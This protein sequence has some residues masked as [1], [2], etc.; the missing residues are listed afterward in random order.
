MS[1]PEK[2]TPAKDPAVASVETAVDRIREVTKWLIGAFA[3]V[4][5]VLA[6]G[7]Q[8]S[9]VGDLTGWRLFAAF[10]A[11]LMALVGIAIAI[12]YA[13]KVLTPKSVSLRGVVAGGSGSPLGKEVES[14]PG[15]LQGHGNSLEEFNLKRQE[16]IA[17]ENDA[18]ARYE[19]SSGDEKKQ[20]AT[21]V[22]RA[23]AKRKRMD[24]TLTWILSY[25]RYLDVSATFRKALTAM[26]VG[27]VLAAAGIALFAWAAHPEGESEDPPGAVAAAPREVTVNLSSAGEDALKESVGTSC[28]TGSMSAIALSG[29]ADAVEMVSVPT[30]SCKV[31]SFVLTPM[32]GTWTAVDQAGA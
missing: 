11:I 31:H 4:G 25:A 8:L 7:S 13:T 6:A 19:T 15:L 26:F 2:D 10:V 14:D 16:A 18:W 24:A 22:K 3:A 23:E 1:E 5:V 21:Q 28:D 9:E 27:A 20:L 29:D 17:A 32:L 30:G 12:L